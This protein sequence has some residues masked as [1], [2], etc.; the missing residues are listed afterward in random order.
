MDSEGERT[1]VHNIVSGH[2]RDRVAQSSLCND[3][4]HQHHKHIQHTL[5]DNALHSTYA[6]DDEK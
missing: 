2:V 5:P 1:S 3:L 4:L 6:N